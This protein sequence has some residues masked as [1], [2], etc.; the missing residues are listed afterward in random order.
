[1]KIIR[2]IILLFL[3]SVNSVLA[4]ETFPD[5]TAIPDWFK[6]EIP[7]DINKLGTHY[8]LTDFGVLNDSTIVQ[9]EIIQSV[10][11]KA[12]N[13]GGGVVIVPKGV[14]L[15]GSLFF[16]PKTHLYLE[17]GAVLKGSDD[18]NN[19]RLLTTRMEGQTV[20]YFAALVNAD[21]V[22]GFTI[23]GKGTLNGNGLRYWKSF[24]L[25]RQFNPQCT[26]MDEMRPRVL[27]V[28]NSNNV[29]ISGITLKNSPF[30]TS[31]FYKCE[32]VRLVD[33]HILAPEHPVKAPSSDAIDLD[34]CKNVHIKNCYL[35]VNDDAIA[36]K[37]GKGP[38]A[39]KDPNNG[40]NSNIIIE[41]NSFG[42]CHSA[43]TCGSE[44][45]HSYNIIFRRNKVDGA[46]R[47]L[48]L[49]MR[50]D[51]PQLY[52]N[53]LVEDITGNVTSMVFIKP[54]TQFFDLKG[55]KDIKMSYA[56]NVTLKNID[57]DCDIAFDIQKSNQYILSDFTFENLNIREKK[58]SAVNVELVNNF[59]LKN[60]KVNGVKL[61]K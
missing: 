57:L 11:D 26:N 12:F 13:A 2:L 20:K 29:Q 46:K 39:D 48:Q 32:Y 38:S 17:E 18:I 51:T 31:H 44:S 27:Y 55:E 1:M 40:S 4:K 60:V 15:S 54:W 52:E 14:F 10:I 25:R 22:D 42:F 24:W 9:T 61:D 47:L 6:K 43:L 23:S 41:D 36:L 33:L 49:K 8:K 58:R 30:W 59:K 16:K 7:T 21:Q 19:F 45:I 53:I 34:A 37:G 3:I 28:S 5:G 56:K 50:P 35:S